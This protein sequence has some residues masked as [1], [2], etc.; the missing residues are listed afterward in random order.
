MN[1]VDILLNSSTSWVS[2]NAPLTVV[3]NPSGYDTS[4]GS[5][6]KIEYDF[7]DQTPIHTVRRKFSIDTPETSAYAYPLDS[8]DPRNQIIEHNYFPSLSSNPQDFF[9][10]V[11]VTYSNSFTPVIYTVP[12]YVYKIDA[13]NG[14]AEGYFEDIH[15]IDG[16]CFGMNNEKLLVFETVNPRYITFLKYNDKLIT[17]S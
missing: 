17:T 12:I 14:L 8:G 16:R 3:L 9:L 7:G 5:V 1:R 13:V 11:K 6:I 15:L 4:S 10:K 2:G